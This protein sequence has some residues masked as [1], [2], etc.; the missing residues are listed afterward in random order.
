MNKYRYFRLHGGLLEL[1]KEFFEGPFTENKR[2]IK[3]FCE[4]IGTADLLVAQRFGDTP[5]VAF[6]KELP[7]TKPYKGHP[8]YFCPRLSTKEGKQLQK[9]MDKLSQPKPDKLFR[10][11]KLEPFIFCGSQWFSP[12]FWYYPEQTLVLVKIMSNFNYTPHAEM[13]ELKEWEFLKL[14]DEGKEKA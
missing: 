2:Q 1:G 6:A 10:V 11:I 12:G 8:G 13:E 9:R 4:E 7:G 5:V 14:Q 3:E